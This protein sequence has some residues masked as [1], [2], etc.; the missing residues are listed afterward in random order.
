VVS[1]TGP[2][3]RILGFRD[4]EMSTGSRKLMFLVSNV[5]P[6]RRAD[7]LSAICEPTV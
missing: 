4:P 5:R 1:V 6:M 7:N 2:Y 3:G